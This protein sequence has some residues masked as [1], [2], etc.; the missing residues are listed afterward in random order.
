MKVVINVLKDVIND[1]NFL[2]VYNS[3]QYLKINDIIWNDELKKSELSSS[4]EISA[5][6]LI[7]IFIE[8]LVKAFN[9]QQQWFNNIKYQQENYL[10]ICTALEIINSDVSKILRMRF[11]VVLQFW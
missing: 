9:N 2:S 10:K 8:K 6:A 7:I 11:N 1:V 3:I 4:D 5:L